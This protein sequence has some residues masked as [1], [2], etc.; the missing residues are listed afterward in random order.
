MKFPKKKEAMVINE[1]QFSPVASINIAA[2][3]LR[4]MLNGKKDERFSPMIG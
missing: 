1:D 3:D 4:A 2:I